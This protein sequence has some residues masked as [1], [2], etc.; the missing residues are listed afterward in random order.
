MKK[1][2]HRFTVE[3]P[4]EQVTAF[5]RDTTALKTLTPFPIF[6]QLHSVEPMA[7][8]STAKFT[9]WAGPLPIRWEALHTNVTQ[10][11]FT[12][13]QVKG[14]YQYWTHHHIFNA[15]GEN[16]TEIIDEVNAIPNPKFFWG[17]ITRLMLFSLPILFA[18]RS[19][20]TRQAVSR[21]S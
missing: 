20:R 13:T 10:N 4:I 16:T 14:P 18:Y 11:G 8:N 17:I 15:I 2:A 19:W 12:D 5:H 9:L 6:V 3:A 1:Y 21:T 7:E